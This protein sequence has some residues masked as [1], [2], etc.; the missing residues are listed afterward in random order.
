MLVSTPTRIG[1]TKTFQSSL[2]IKK[3]PEL[4]NFPL[5]QNMKLAWHH[6]LPISE[7]PTNTF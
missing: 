3:K 1:S 7:C 6:D 5:Y 2:K 4:N